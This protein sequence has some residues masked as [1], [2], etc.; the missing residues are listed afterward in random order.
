MKNCSI[1]QCPGQFKERRITHVVKHH[2]EVIV[3]ENVPAEVCSECGEVLLPL[4]SVEAIETMLKN[5][6]KPVRTAP[7]YQMPDAVASA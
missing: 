5:P 2:G 1:R 4:L 7:V 6:G 3:L